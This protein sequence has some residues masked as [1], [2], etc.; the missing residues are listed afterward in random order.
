MTFAIK[1]VKNKSKSVSFYLACSQINIIITSN[2]QLYYF[3]WV[4]KVHRFLIN[5]AILNLKLISNLQVFE[6]NILGKLF[7]VFRDKGGCS[8]GEKYYF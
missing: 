6:F 2:C 3:F 7:N 4:E 8:A 5:L 1:V